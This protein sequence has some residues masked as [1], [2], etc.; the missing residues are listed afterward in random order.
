MMSVRMA[1]IALALVAM[2]ETAEDS[3]KTLFCGA[4]TS[5]PYWCKWSVR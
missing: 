5:V 2:L 3:S 4:A 1:I